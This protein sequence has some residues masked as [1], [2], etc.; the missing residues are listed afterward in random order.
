MVINVHLIENVCFIIRHV[1]CRFTSSKYKQQSKIPQNGIKIS[2]ELDV[3]HENFT[4]LCFLDSL[5]ARSVWVSRN[6]NSSSRPASIL[7][8]A[9]HPANDHP[10]I[11]KFRPSVHSFVPWRLN[12][13]PSSPSAHVFDAC[14]VPASRR[15]DYE[16]WFR[17]VP[18]QTHINSNNCD[19]VP[20][21]ARPKGQLNLFRWS[22]FRFFD[23]QRQTWARLLFLCHMTFLQLQYIY[24]YLTFSLNLCIWKCT[25][26]SFLLH[27][28][29]YPTVFCYS[30]FFTKPLFNR[31]FHYN[32]NVLDFITNQSPLCNVNIKT[33]IKM[34]LII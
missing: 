25:P 17:S 24:I 12:L 26:I 29:F 31:F 16:Y 9:S 8:T 33:T 5:R 10:V 1:S 6:R 14:C 15:L 11:L 4:A 23:T 19:V 18:F 3:T 30:T 32:N 21:T 2:E 28:F 13:T 27:S 34:K 20:A 7:G 22:T